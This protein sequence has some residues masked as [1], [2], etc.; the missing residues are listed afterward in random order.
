MLRFLPALLVAGLA[1]APALADEFTDTLDSAIKAYNDGD[2]AGAQQDVE[3]AGKLLASMKAEGLAKFLPEAQAGWTRADENTD[4]AGG[5]MAML[6]GGTTTGATYKKADGT[7]LTITL[8]ANSPMVNGIAAMVGGMAAMGSGK[9]MRIQRTEFANNDGEL[10]GV[11][12]GKV[13]ISVSGNATVE[14][15]TAYLEAMDF[16]GLA[17]F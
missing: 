11:V 13:M 15:K 4:E 3:Y 12:N 6:G 5:M 16:K 10:Q 17:E 2:V 14:D 9:P 7:D 8:V 1:A